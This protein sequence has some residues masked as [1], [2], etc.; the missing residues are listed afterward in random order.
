[1]NRASGQPSEVVS[2]SPSSRI[3]VQEIARLA[4]DLKANPR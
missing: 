1:M 3:T 4:L 2:N